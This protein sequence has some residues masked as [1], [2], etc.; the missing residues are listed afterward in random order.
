MNNTE[1]I[2]Y[3]TDG[4]VV[5]TEIQ[6]GKEFDAYCVLAEGPSVKRIEFH[7]LPLSEFA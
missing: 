4:Q 3:F 2:I 7:I 5:K 1:V 6:G